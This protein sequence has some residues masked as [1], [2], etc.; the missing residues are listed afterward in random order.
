MRDHVRLADLSHSIDQLTMAL[1]RRESDDRII[2]VQL[3]E[4]ADG[5]REAV[6]M[7]LAYALRRREL[8]GREPVN[9]RAIAAL[10]GTVRRMTHHPDQEAE[11]R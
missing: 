7:A 6:A 5:E 8:G 9:D 2:E 3:V 4:L 10:A 1:C 11:T